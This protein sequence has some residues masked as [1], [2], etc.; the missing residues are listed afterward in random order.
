M[1]SILYWRCQFWGWFGMMVWNFSMAIFFGTVSWWVLWVSLIMVG[2]G[3]LLTHAGRWIVARRGWKELTP[4]PL[5]PRVLLTSVAMGTILG[6]ATLP[7]HCRAAETEMASGEVTGVQLAVLVSVSYSFVFLG[8]FLIYFCYHYFQRGR[9]AAAAEWRLRA[10]MRDNELRTLRAQLNP[11][12]L[13]NSLNSL[14]GLIPESPARAQEAVT[15]LAGLL[16]HTLRLSSR[17]TITL[18]EELAAAEHYLA[19]ET[20]RFEE[21]LGCDLDV[22]PELLDQAV[23]PMLLHNLVENAVKHGIAHRRE[24]GRIGIQ[25][26]R[27]EGD[28][29]RLRVT[30]PGTLGGTSPSGHAGPRSRLD[31]S[32]HLDFDPSSHSDARDHA[33]FRDRLDDFT[34]ALRDFDREVRDQV[35]FRGGLDPSG[36]SGAR[37]PSGISNQTVPSGHSGAR[38][39]SGISNHTDPSGHSGARERPSFHRHSASPGHAAPPISDGAGLGL[40]NVREQLHLL[41][42]DEASFRIYESGPDEVAAEVTLPRKVVRPADDR[43]FHPAGDGSAGFPGDERTPAAHPPEK[44]TRYSTTRPSTR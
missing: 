44:G 39:P 19:L 15:A 35:G 12:F 36:R 41:H 2:G 18:G 6:L 22:D 20:I 30:N 25:V 29:V 27:E 31:P 7:I 37:G 26:H 40:R 38:G 24:G 42:G 32:S 1:T 5:A 34:E 13:F 21:R 10:A 11:H 17:P 9:E 3:I 43:T 33:D 23:P 4:G 16:R 28:T 8:W 14:R